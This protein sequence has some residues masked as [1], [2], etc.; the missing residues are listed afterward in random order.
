MRIIKVINSFSPVVSKYNNTLI[1][2]FV[3]LIETFDE[4]DTDNDLD[5]TVTPL[6]PE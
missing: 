2:L 6:F 3:E 4:N 1:F 5:Q